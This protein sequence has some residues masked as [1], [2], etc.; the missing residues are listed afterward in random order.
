MSIRRCCHID[1][2]F[3]LTHSITPYLFILSKDILSDIIHYR[4]YPEIR[5]IVVSFFA[6][7]QTSLDHTHYHMIKTGMMLRRN[8][9]N[10][11]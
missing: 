4:G 5:I 9:F 7:R 11:F 8:A 6:I 1:N 10:L 2:A 3:K